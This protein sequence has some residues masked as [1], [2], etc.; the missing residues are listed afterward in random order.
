MSSIV[1]AD[2]VDYKGHPADKSKT[3]GWLSAALITVVY[4]FLP[5]WLQ[6]WFWSVI[7]TMRTRWSIRFK[8]NLQLW[9][10]EIIIS[11]ICFFVG[12]EFC[13]RLSTKGIAVN[14]VTFLGGTMHLPSATSDNMLTNA[15]GTYFFLCLV[16]CLIA[17]S[18]LGKYK[19]LA[20]SAAIQAPLSYPV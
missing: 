12:V 3:G 9:W 17:D 7:T 8:Q 16:G 6:H 2:A 1:V 13:G 20:N 10:W 11:I 4:M 18:F 15:V 19:T 14:L 5:S